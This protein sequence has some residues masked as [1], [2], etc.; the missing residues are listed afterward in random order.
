MKQGAKDLK[1]TL[2]R[3]FEKHEFD[4]CEMSILVSLA[5]EVESLDV[6]MDKIELLKTGWK[7]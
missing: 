7:R 6:S 3:Q 5:E 4:C 2:D 1:M